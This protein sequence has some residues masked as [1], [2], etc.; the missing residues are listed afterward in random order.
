MPFDQLALLTLEAVVVVCL[1]L[2]LFHKRASWG[3]SPLFIAIGV[4]QYMQV[5]LA[6]FVYVDVTPFGPVSPGSVVLFTSTLFAILLV[7]IYEDILETRKLICGLALANV[8]AVWM[9]YAASLHLASPAALPAPVLPPQF[10]SENL[11]VL[12]V[13]TVVLVL[14]AIL[15]VVVYEALSP[16]RFPALVRI[17]V[18]VTSALFADHVL[19]ATGAFV[20]TAQY[21]DRLVS[22]VLGKA[23]F[24]AFFATVLWLYLRLIASAPRP[25]HSYGAGRALKILS[26]RQRFERLDKEFTSLRARETE[27]V[28]ELNA[29]RRKLAS[30][31]RG[32]IETE[33][34]LREREERLSA[35]SRELLQTQET[36]KRALAQELHDEVGQLLTTLRLEI[37]AGRKGGDDGREALNRADAA[38]DSTLEQIRSLSLRLRPTVLDDHGLAAAVERSARST[39]LT[40]GEP[41]TLERRPDPRAE[42]EATSTVTP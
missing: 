17:Y 2:A 6:S 39:V 30:E 29:I 28:A 35:L 7:Y 27:K 14:D 15:I 40:F 37:F 9:S 22:G 18:T 24:G 8:V 42:A 5:I 36:E 33:F 38:V 25:E 31:A 4:F 12:A 19:F 1:I 10:F 41:P 34:R 21:V 11:R 13:G 26:Y 20:G 23:T 16:S 3:V 32:R